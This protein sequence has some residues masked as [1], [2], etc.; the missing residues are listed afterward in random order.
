M[1]PA[2]LAARAGGAWGLLPGPGGEDGATAR[3]EIGACPDKAVGVRGDGLD[4]DRPGLD[5]LAPDL[6]DPT[7]RPHRAG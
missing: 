3:T 1:L 5:V 4:F 2:I 6:D 7:A